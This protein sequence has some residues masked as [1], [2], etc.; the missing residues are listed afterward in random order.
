ALRDG[1]GDGDVDRHADKAER[2]HRAADVD[3]NDKCHDR[4]AVS[5]SATIRGRNNVARRRK[6][7]TAGRVHDALCNSAERDFFESPKFDRRLNQ[8]NAVDIELD[9]KV[10]PPAKRIDRNPKWLVL[11]RER[12][13]QTHRPSAEELQVAPGID[14]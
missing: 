10:P 6:K 2:G 5:T 11:A 13:L 3:K 4:L 1:Q 9:E 12:R 14:R 8:C 7:D